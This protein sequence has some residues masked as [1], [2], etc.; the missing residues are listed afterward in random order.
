VS[1]L[2]LIGLGALFL[3]MLLAAVI[4]GY[5]IYISGVYGVSLAC[6]SIP[7]VGQFCLIW[8]IW[9]ATGAFFNFYT[10]ACLCWLTLA[11]F[12]GNVAERR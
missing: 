5:G 7:V 11:I 1:L 4:Y 6:S 9:S 10:I 12:V 2:K 8:A 3:S